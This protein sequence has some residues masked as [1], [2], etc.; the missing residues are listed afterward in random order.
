MWSHLSKIYTVIRPGVQLVWRFFILR[1]QRRSYFSNPKIVMIDGSQ[2]LNWK[3]LKMTCISVEF[4]RNLIEISVRTHCTSKQDQEVEMNAHMGWTAAHIAFLSL[5]LVSV[6]TSETF[7]PWVLTGACWSGLYIARTKMMD[8]CPRKTTCPAP[9]KWESA[10]NFCQ[11][12][13]PDMWHAPAQ[14]FSCCV[15]RE[16]EERNLP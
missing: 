2:I 8:G 14:N 4:C 10:C 9:R 6:V 16:E 5:L 13:W 3:S 15:S 11:D 1:R 12:R 7:C